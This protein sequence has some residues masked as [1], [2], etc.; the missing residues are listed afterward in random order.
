M[1]IYTVSTK[2]IWAFEGASN[3]TTVGAERKQKLKEMVEQGKTDGA[4]NRANDPLLR[5][6]I[7]VRDFI[8]QTSADEYISFMLEALEKYDS[9]E[10]LLSATTIPTPARP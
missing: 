2:L 8:D 5:Q 3:D 9:S 4:C 10:L 7:I 6:E 1:S